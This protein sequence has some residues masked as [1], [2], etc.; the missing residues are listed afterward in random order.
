MNLFCVIDIETI[1]SQSLPDSV[2]PEFDPDTVKIGNIKDV[3]KIDEKINAAEQEFNN[4]LDKKMS[5][6]PDL[7]E[8]VCFGVKSSDN[9][10]IYGHDQ[11]CLV[12][13][14]WDV[15]KKAY[16]D[17]IPLVSFNGIAFDLPVLWH[18]AM[19]L[20]IPV[21]AQMYSDLTKKYDNPYHYDLM[22][23]LGGW[24]RTKWKSLDFYLKL[25]G[26]GEKSGDGSEIYGWWKVREYEK[27]KE[28]CENDVKMTGQLFERLMPWIVKAIP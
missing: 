24:D 6:D 3:L 22:Q 7:C 28:H 25:F 18:Q 2:K 8:V 13:D 14:A 15:I 10:W 12:S 9:E 5:L 16:L 4:A 23:I 20:T 21:D 11:P 17:H 1:P 19:C 27:I 26:I